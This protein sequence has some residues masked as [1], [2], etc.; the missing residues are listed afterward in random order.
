[1]P[2]MAFLPVAP[3]VPGTS[4]SSS[5]VRYVKTI[6]T[7]NC[8]WSATVRM[9]TALVENLGEPAAG[10]GARAFP[11]AEA[12]AAAPESFYRDVV[13]AGYR[14]AYLRSLAAGVADGS[15]EL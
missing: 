4:H 15:V 13:R 1:M 7:T 10:G 2:N 3:G 6:C 8:A 11:S 14:S 9:V 12:M 5:I